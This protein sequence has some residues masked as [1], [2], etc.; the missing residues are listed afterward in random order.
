MW[1]EVQIWPVKRCYKIIN[2]L[3]DSVP[4]SKSTG[5]IWKLKVGST[6]ICGLLSL[7][8][9]L[10]TLV[11]GNVEQCQSQVCEAPKCRANHLHRDI[12][13]PG[14]EVPGGWELP[15][16]ARD[17]IWVL[18]KSPQKKNEKKTCYVISSEYL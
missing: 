4:S 15:G 18:S 16:G 7:P 17:W 11:T 8:A 6:G 1:I 13:S 12:R 9:V 10:V 5:Q 14:T 2:G 3:E